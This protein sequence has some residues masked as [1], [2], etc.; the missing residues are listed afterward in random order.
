MKDPRIT[1][2]NRTWIVRDGY[3]HKPNP[4]VWYDASAVSIDH[5]GLLILKTHYNPKQFRPTNETRITINTGSGRVYCEDEFGYGIFEAS[6]K[7]PIGK[8]LWPAFWIYSWQSW[9]PEI[10]I[11]EAYSN[12]RENYVNLQWNPFYIW[13]V[14]TNVHYE[15]NGNINSIGG[16]RHWFGIK[17]PARNFIKYRLEW[18]PDSIK[19]FHNEF[20]VRTITDSKILNTIKGSTMKVVLNN[21][22]LDGINHSPDSE[23]FVKNFE[24]TPY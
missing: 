21:S 11:F 17:D 4:K 19:I 8:E 9:P 18:K 3:Y 5:N 12:K 15:L 7:L 1:F 20:P 10:D 24:F 23:M 22:V 2:S 16:K 14:E 6:V 13:K